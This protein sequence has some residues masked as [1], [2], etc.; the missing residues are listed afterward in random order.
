MIAVISKIILC[1]KIMTNRKIVCLN[2]H[3]IYDLSPE[4]N[5]SGFIICK[6]CMQEHVKG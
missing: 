5:E 2:G 4:L 6:E 3:F 1:F